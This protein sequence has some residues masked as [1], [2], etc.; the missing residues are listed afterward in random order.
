LPG[1]WFNASEIHALLACQELL[2]NV[3]PGLLDQ[4]VKPLRDRIDEILS[5]KQLAT[6][7]V[8][9]RIKIL[10]MTYRALPEGVFQIIAE[11]TAQRRRV[12]IIHHGREKGQV[13]EREVSPQRL[14][15]YRDNWYM[16]GWCHLRGNLRTFSIDRIRAVRLNARKAKYISDKA[17]DDYFARSYGIFAGK[18]KYVAVLRFSENA[19][20][21]VATEHWHPRQEMVWNDGRLEL[22]VPC[23]DP[24]E[25]IQDILKHGEDVEVIS[26]PELTKFVKARLSRALSQYK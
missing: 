10:R 26:P 3:C 9:K 20:P 22:R 7:D 5:I 12:I 15:H 1:L 24:R 14:V 21:W 6:G 4:H 16:D 23:S 13:T 2:S 18:P 25:L 11:A 17:L 19:S 8:S